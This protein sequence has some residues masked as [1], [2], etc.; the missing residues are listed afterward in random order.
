MTKQD[1]SLEF[2][3]AGMLPESAEIDLLIQS[4]SDIAVYIDQAGIVSGIFVSPECP[5]LGCLDHWV[6]RPFSS[7]LNTESKKKFADRVTEINGGLTETPGTIELNHCDNAAWEFPIRYSPLRIKDSNSIL[8]LGRDLQPIAEVQ[9]RLVNE[10]LAHERDLQ[11]IRGAETF[12]RVVLEA[13][14]TPLVVVEPETGR[15][16]DINSAAATL[17]GAKPDTL[18]GNTF[19]QAFQGLRRGELMETL[20]NVGSSEESRSI[21]AVARRSGLQV[22]IFPEYFRA[23]GELC[24]LCH[25]AQVGQDDTGGTEI[26]RFL[27]AL[28]TSSPDAIVIVDTKGIIREANESF[29]VLADAAQLRDVKGKHFAKFLVRGEVDAQ[30]LLEGAL[31]E[32]RIR[33]YSTQFKSSVGTR[34]SVELSMTLLGSGSDAGF[35]M[36]I[37]DVGQN[38]RPVDELPQAMVSEYAL[39]NVM[40]LVGTASL[41]ELVTATSDVIERICISTALQMTKNNRVAAAEMLGLSRQSLYVKLRKY[42]MLNSEAQE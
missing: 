39:Q 22:E 24:M 19:N 33:N 20:Q 11:K 4:A 2:S 5:S 15:I 31:R 8:M 6:G 1:P 13:S 42:D 30:L 36:I 21:K 3:Y 29:L 27:T 38:A 16:R 40:D 25:L 18:P 37:R 32:G 10:Q 26:A 23:A 17:L 41:K 12:Y 35:G 34:A 9:Q 14:A 28:F 7:F